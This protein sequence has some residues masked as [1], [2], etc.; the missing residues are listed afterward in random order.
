M[1]FNPDDM[2]EKLA[3]RTAFIWGPFYALYYNLRLLWRE[4]F[5]RG[6]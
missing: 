5:G 2:V 3:M 6:E 1:V 4:L